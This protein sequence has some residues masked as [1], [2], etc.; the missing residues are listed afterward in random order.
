MKYL[1]KTLDLGKNE[2][3]FHLSMFDEMENFPR[4]TEQLVIGFGFIIAWNAWVWE[5]E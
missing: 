3:L 2:K 4:L 1:W 5:C